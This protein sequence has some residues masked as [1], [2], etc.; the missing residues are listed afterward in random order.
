MKA[1]FKNNYTWK[2]G[3]KCPEGMIGCAPDSINYKNTK[4]IY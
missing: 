1:T 3:G 2:S 4:T